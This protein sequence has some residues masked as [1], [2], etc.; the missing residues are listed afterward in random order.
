MARKYEGGRWTLSGARFQRGAVELVAFELALYFGYRYG[1]AIGGAMA[2]PI[3]FPTSVLLCGMLRVRPRYGWLLMLA[4]LPIRLLVLPANA[5]LWLS[6]VDWAIDG[7]TAILTAALLRRVMAN[8]ARFSGLQDL[9]LYWLLAVLLVPAIAAA[10]AAFAGLHQGIDFSSSWSGTFR[11][12]ALAN[13]VVTPTLLYW[14]LPPITLPAWT[15]ARRAEAMVLLVGMLASAST[16]FVGTSSSPA[17][18]DARL[19]APL[20]FL[21]WAALRFGTSGTSVGMAV[22]AAFAARAAAA[23]RSMVE[24]LQMFLALQAAPLYLV[25]VLVDQNRLV[26]ASLLESQHLFRSM[27]DTAPVL[28]WMAGA[29]RLCEFLNKAWLDFTGRSLEEGLG[30]GWIESVHPD[31][32]Q[33]CQ[34]IFDSHFD[35]RQPFEIEYRLRRHD[36]QYRWVLARGLARYA[37]NGEFVGYIGSAVDVTDFAEQEA[38][39][40]E[41]EKRYRE[42]VDSQSEFVCRCLPDTRLTFANDAYC[43]FTGRKRESLLGTKLLALLPNSAHDAIRQSLTKAAQGESSSWECDVPLA[44][45][46]SA[47][48]H[49]VCCAIRDPSG[50]LDEFQVIGRD[51]SDRRHAEEADRRLARAM[52]LA[53]IGELTAIMAHEVTQPLSAILGNAEAAE[54]LL[55]SPNPP[56]AELQEIIADIHGV[57]L[58]AGG[59]IRRIRALAQRRPPELTAVDVNRLVEVALQLVA[60]DASRRRVRLRSELT[61]ELPLAFADGPSIE[62]VLLNLI[63][64]GMDAMDQTAQTRRE[65]VVQTRH[66]VGTE[67]VEV[68]VVDSGHGIPVDRMEQLFESFFT[69][70]EQGTGLGLSVASSIIQAHGGRIWAQ[71]DANGGAAFHFTLRAVEQV[72]AVDLQP[73]GLR[74][75]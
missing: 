45:G 70:K 59:A 46:R 73:D 7:L 63:M 23:N 71:N 21:L 1:L 10:V 44:D 2:A 31:D 13:L 69:T 49:W 75:A 53:T 14:V 51:V 15:G 17:V 72:G 38:A 60:G 56:I 20:V 32:R 8:L 6:V 33:R 24:P 25:A 27:A 52:R 64:N 18:I 43:R 29:D 37:A 74:S 55:K 12:Y 5:P 68:I 58:R 28:V 39:L 41:S 19:Y 57:G 35:A 22:L 34:A 40:R 66:V 11:G 47:A 4:A 65:L 9:A 54:I 16:A 50:E 61:S 67:T 3:W 26:R 36:G 42:V 30:N 48:Q 62:Q